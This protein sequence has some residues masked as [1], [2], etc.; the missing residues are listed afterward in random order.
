MTILE[1]LQSR[2]PQL[3][4]CR[5]EI[6]KALDLLLTCYRNGGQVLVCGNG[7]S[8]ADA[9]HIVGEL[10]K[11]FKR[12][13]D[14]DASVAAKLPPELA[15]NG[16]AFGL[17][18][19]SFMCRKHDVVDGK[20]GWN[21]RNWN[22]FGADH[23][24]SAPHGGEISYYSSRDQREFLDPKGLYGTTW[25]QAAAKYHMTFV[26]AND[27]PR[28]PFATPERFRSAA[29]ECGPDLVAS[30][31][32]PRQSGV[33]VTVRNDGVAPPY[34]DLGVAVGGKPADGTLKGLLPG[35]SR[36]LFARGASSDGAVTLVSKKLLAPVPLARAAD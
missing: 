24:K 5:D 13:R 10:L 14:I 1:E 11:K 27:S 12:H 8:A 36:V 15:A 7:G 4:G 35:E 20:G 29:R 32:K 19:D 34:H 28:G 6:A 22:A 31:V 23:W 3:G 30:E 2:Y 9:E 33:E 21:E 18:D 25:A 26:I 16:L 17:F